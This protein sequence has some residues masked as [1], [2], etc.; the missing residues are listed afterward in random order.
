MNKYLKKLNYYG[1]KE[2]F[3]IARKNFSILKSKKRRIAIIAFSTWI[4]LILSLTI[5]TILNILSIWSVPSIQENKDKEIIENI[6]NYNT[7]ANTGSEN[8]YIEQIKTS[9]QST[10]SLFDNFISYTPDPTG[11][12]SCY[13]QDGLTCELNFIPQN[14]LSFP[15]TNVTMPSTQKIINTLLSLVVPFGF[16]L[17]SLQGFNFLVG[18]NTAELKSFLFRVVGGI[19]LLIITPFILSVSIMLVNQ[20][21]SFL[22]GNLYLTEF[23]IKFVDSL[24]TETPNNLFQELLKNFF[25]LGNNGGIN[26]LSYLYSIPV[27][28][29]LSLVFLLL[30]YI[31]F[32]FILRFLNL[33][34]LSA[35]Y[36]FTIVF[37][38]HPK[39]SQIVSN[40]W[41]QWTTFIIQQPV[42]VLGFVII[43]EVLFS[44]FD[45]GLSLEVMII[46]IGLLLFLGTISVF[47]SRLW[48]DIYTAVANNVSAGMAANLV[49]T[50]FIDKPLEYA[51]RLA[52]IKSEQSLAGI[53]KKY[54]DTESPSSNDSKSTTNNTSEKTPYKSQLSK[55][56]QTSGL[57][58][59]ELSN[60]KLS[61]SGNFYLDSKDSSS[62][63]KLYISPQ[64][65]VKD[66]VNPKNLSS[67]RISNLILQDTSNTKK[68]GSY[69]GGIKD[70]AGENLGHAKNMSLNYK[71]NDIKVKENMIMAKSYNLLKGVQAI[72]VKND[73]KNGDKS[74][75][76][77]NIIKIH[78]YK[79]VLNNKNAGY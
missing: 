33:Y 25:E 37:S 50:S 78:T 79:E 40:Y 51:G 35:V 39:T 29:P 43:K 22:L 52:S 34:F 65:A 60:G 73:T 76:G 30:L 21:S 15:A 63:Q 5:L 59:N 16:I 2:S 20:L 62:I 68:I 24:E 41:K 36:P 11:R 70:Y 26:P 64:D 27:L 18:E 67:K 17:I 61:T 77:D 8:F 42:F 57:N 4:F 23:I 14:T 69:N 3:L 31:S 1:F 54:L 55:E 6:E 44:L 28:I 66:G 12:S 45:N 75:L 19:I 48:G 56:L 49:K 72:G 7:Y 10:S 53:S 74:I 71:S 13:K 47:A 9:L 38:F 32:Q 46:F 58:V